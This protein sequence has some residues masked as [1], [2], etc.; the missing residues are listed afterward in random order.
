MNAQEA[1]SEERVQSRTG[2]S[3]HKSSYLADE[4]EAKGA[5]QAQH[6]YSIL[7]LGHSR[8]SE[9]I[10][11]GQQIILPVQWLKHAENLY[12][13][14]EKEEYHSPKRRVQLVG[15]V[16]QLKVRPKPLPCH[17]MSHEVTHCHCH[18]YFQFVQHLRDDYIDWRRYVLVGTYQRY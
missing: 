5:E 12:M 13:P 11:N 18:Y 4:L 15:R 2:P 8:S 7:R 9:H 10:L 14:Q 17:I 6:M 16:D 3:L 1:Q